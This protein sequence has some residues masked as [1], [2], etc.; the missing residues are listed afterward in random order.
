MAEDFEIE[1]QG[2]H[3]YLVHLHG[4]A[5]DAEAWVRVTPGV[6]QRLG[7]GEQD[8]EAVVRRT[9]AFLCRYQEAADFPAVVE[10]EDVLASYPDYR[11][12]LAR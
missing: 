5:E 1:S 11:T 2:D 9:I 10:L 12:A 4:R 6:L 7:V 3:E 8:E